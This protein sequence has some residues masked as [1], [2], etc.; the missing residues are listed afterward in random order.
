MENASL[1]I[2]AE[3]PESVLPPVDLEE[4]AG[5]QRMWVMLKGDQTVA[6]LASAESFHLQFADVHGCKTSAFIT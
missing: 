5:C 1:L 2:A 4:S 6:P 3:E